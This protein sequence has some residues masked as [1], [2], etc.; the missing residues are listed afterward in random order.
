MVRAGLFEE[1]ETLYRRGILKGTALAGIGYKEIIAYIRGFSTYDETIELIKRGSRRYAKRQLTWFRRNDD[2]IY[3]NP[4][5]NITE[6]AVEMAK[7]FLKS[8]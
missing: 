1:A 3:L 4:E 5:E 6:K 7:E 8:E 2:I